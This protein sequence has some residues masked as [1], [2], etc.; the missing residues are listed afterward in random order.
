MK[1]GTKEDP[2]RCSALPMILTCSGFHA[3]RSVYPDS[4]GSA[5]E[6]GT[7]VGRGAEVFHHGESADKAVEVALGEIEGRLTGAELTQIEETIRAY[8][9]DPRNGPLGSMQVLPESQEKELNFEYKGIWFSGHMDQIRRHEDGKLY[10][11]DLKNGRAYGGVQMVNAYAAQLAMYSIGATQYYGEPV[12]YGGIVR[13][14]GYIG[15][16]NSK[17]YVG[18][19]PVFFH[20]NWPDGAAEYLADRIV[21]AVKR[22]QNGEI[23]LCPG[24]HCNFCPGGGVANCTKILTEEFGR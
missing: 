23:D 6:M 22:L 4:S 13:T 21:V 7:A 1:I 5:A 14:R 3:M 2:V 19:R 24:G 17:L 8:S 10:V 12:R 9:E 18:D 11:W 16:T 20:A 15:K